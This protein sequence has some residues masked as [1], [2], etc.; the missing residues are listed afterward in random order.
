MYCHSE[1]VSINS[2]DDIKHAFFINLE[3][4]IDRKEHVEME[5]TK[6]GIQATRFNAIKMKNVIKKN[7]AN[8]KK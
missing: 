3:H 4:R 7:I 6:L 2:I 5:L 8:Y 1:S